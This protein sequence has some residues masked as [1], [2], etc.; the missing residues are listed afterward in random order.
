ME[1]NEFKKSNKKL[2]S[3]NVKTLIEN[4]NKLKELSEVVLAVQ[5]K[6]L[7]HQRSTEETYSCQSRRE[8]EELEYRHCE[9]LKE[10]RMTW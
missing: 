2:I 1:D 7:A 4:V 3:S 10:I 6:I 8:T 5:S 9:K